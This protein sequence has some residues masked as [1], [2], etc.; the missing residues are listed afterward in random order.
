[1]RCLEVCPSGLI[2]PS[3]VKSKR[4]RA[5]SGLKKARRQLTAA[6]ALACYRCFLP[7]LAGFTRLRCAGPA[8]DEFQYSILGSR[9]R[10]RSR[11]EDSE[12]NWLL[13]GL[14]LGKVLRL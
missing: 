14:R 10:K 6:H 7:D 11:S 1:M 13:P 4:R 2:G 8:P 5:N 3:L 12:T 9:G